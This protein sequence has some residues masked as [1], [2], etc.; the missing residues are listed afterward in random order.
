LKQ[1]LVTA[2]VLCLPDILKDFQVYCD[3]SRQ[4]LHSVLMHDG[5]VVSYASR[6][7]KHHER[8]YPTHDLELA[9]VVGGVV[10][11]M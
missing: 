11:M 7:L 6:Q 1:R 8:N 4:G 3:A 9:S 5:R 2:P 10:L